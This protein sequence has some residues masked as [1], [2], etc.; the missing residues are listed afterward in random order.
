M[1]G[2]VNVRPGSNREPGRT[3]DIQIQ[4]KAE[5]TKAIPH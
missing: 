2:S 1:G 3:K 4:R 5:E